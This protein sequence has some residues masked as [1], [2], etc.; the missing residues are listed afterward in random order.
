VK[1]RRARAGEG[2]AVADVW[3]R[4]RRAAFPAIPLPVHSDDETRAWLTDV[5]A[6]NPDVWVLE[7][8]NERLLAVMVLDG[9][10]ID[11]LYV[12]P[13]WCGLGL[14]GRLLERAKVLRPDGLHLRTFTANSGARRFYERHGFVATAFSDGNNEEHAPDVEYAWKRL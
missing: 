11:Q 4:S 2:S 6:S 10:S 1:V 7:H 9:S 8:D 3:L 13:E 5:V 12:L 14:G